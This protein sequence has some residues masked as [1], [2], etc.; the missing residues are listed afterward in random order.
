MA[1]M[2]DAD[3]MIYITSNTEE[4]VEAV[5]KKINEKLN[6]RLSVYYT[7]CGDLSDVAYVPAK[8]GFVTGSTRFYGC[9][10]WAYQCNIEYFGKW[11]DHDEVLTTL[12]WKIR[13]VYKDFEPGREVIY[14]AIDELEHQ[15]NEDLDLVH[16]KNIDFTKYA[17]NPYNYIKL[18]ELDLCDLECVCDFFNIGE[19]N[20]HY[21][22]SLEDYEEK[23]ADLLK[24]SIATV[25]EDYRFTDYE[26][27][28]KYILEQI[29][30]LAPSAK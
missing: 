9:G 8:N 18:N 11:M 20:A 4:D 13:F 30:C 21:Y 29:P 7:D 3:G 16:I 23:K 26:E 14:E 25:F 27:A 17:F 10:R 15:A 28:K 19:D 22:S 2:S 1:N 5:F 6:Q 12:P 24:S